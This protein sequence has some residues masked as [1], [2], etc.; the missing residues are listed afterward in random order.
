MMRRSVCGVRV[1]QAKALAHLAHDRQ[2]VEDAR[3]LLRVVRPAGGRAVVLEEAHFAVGADEPID[4][5]VR[6]ARLDLGGH[7]RLL[8]GREHHAAAQRR[9]L[10]HAVGDAHDGAGDE[11]R[12]LLQRHVARRLHEVRAHDEALRVEGVEGDRLT[13]LRHHLVRR[14][15]ILGSKE[16]VKVRDC[17]AADRRIHRIPPCVACST[18][19]ST[20]VGNRRM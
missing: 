1:L 20:N 7:V 16:L 3:Q 8:L 17:R 10:H 6:L 19:D 11:Q 4:A 18:R 14:L 2:R 15:P 13:R 12:R 9:V 5:P